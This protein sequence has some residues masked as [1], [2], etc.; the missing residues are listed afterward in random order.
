MSWK[1]WDHSHK[2]T[3]SILTQKN[4]DFTL[5]WNNGVLNGGRNQASWDFFM[6]CWEIYGDV[7]GD[8]YPIQP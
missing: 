6:T 1:N 3:G 2:F 5:S 8:I 4:G 7:I